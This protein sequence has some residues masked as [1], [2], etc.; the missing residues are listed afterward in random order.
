MHTGRG[1]DIVITCRVFA[2]PKPQVTWSRER[3]SRQINVSSDKF[4][5]EERGTEYRLK[6][7]KVAPEEDFDN[8][9]CHASNKFGFTV[10]NIELVGF[11][12]TARIISRS[13]IYLCYVCSHFASYDVKWEVASNSPV[14]KFRLRYRKQSFCPLFYG[15]QRVSFCPSTYSFYPCVILT[16]EVYGRR[17]RNFIF[18]N[19]CWDRE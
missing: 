4:V 8:Y 11:P 19:Q 18:L 15:R 16:R 13:T 1:V 12:T 14:T 2:E 5:L 17:G 10:G 7:M 3:D 6:I 9:T